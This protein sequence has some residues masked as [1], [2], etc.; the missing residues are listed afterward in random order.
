[1]E[2]WRII[3]GRVNAVGQH[4]RTRDD[5]RKSVHQKKGIWRA[6][7][8]DVPTLGVYGRWSTH[9]RKRFGGPEMLARKMAEAQPGMAYQR[10][11]GARRTPDPPD[12]PHTGGGLS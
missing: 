1:M 11:R 2:L 6:I 7:A 12:A 5:I 4:P 3:V 8:K 10:G 9:C